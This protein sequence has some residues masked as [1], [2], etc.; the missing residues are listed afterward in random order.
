MS[1]EMERVTVEPVCTLPSGCAASG[2]TNDGHVIAVCTQ[3][4]NRICFSWDGLCGEPFDRLPELRDKSLAIFASDDGNHVAYVGSRGDQVFVGRDGGEDPAFEGFSQS[5]PPVFGGG[6]RHLAY[7]AKPLG[8]EYRLIV[9]GTPVGTAE[10]APIEAAYSL[11]GERLAYVEMRG[12]TRTEVEFRIVLDGQPGEW[13]AGMRNA[14]GAMQFSPDGRRF[15]YYTI[16]GQGHARWFVDGIGQRVINDTRP[17]SLARMRGVGVVDPPLPARFSPDSSRFAYFADVVEKGVAMI[18]DD[19][20]GPLVK[21]V[22]APVFSPDSRHLAYGAQTDVKTVAL[23]LDGVASGEWPATNGGM[24]V[25]SPDGNRLAMT[26]ERE[27]GGLFRKRR[28]FSVAID[29]RRSPEEEAEDSSGTATFSPDGRQIAW[30]LQRNGRA[31]PILDGV[32]QNVPWSVESDVRFDAAGRLVY[33]AQVAGSWT[34]VHGDQPGPLADDMLSLRTL[35]ERFGR[36]PWAHGPS[37]FRISATGQVAWVGVVDG[38]FRP[39]LDDELGP[40][41]DGIL[42][43]QVGHGGDVTWWA[44]RDDVV[45]RVDRATDDVRLSKRV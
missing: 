15:A 28:L 11:D 35:D 44:Q 42:A 16:D 40:A 38:K 23:V 2:V 6:G 1:V 45:Y 20:A 13:F 17:M 14:P 3:P 4:D 29:G 31:A 9:D 19:V 7:G 34:V 12:A 39:V 30:W 37:P 33:G 24:A 10:V 18:E 27:E 21:A 25:F 43:C 36:D 26:L 22:G 5:V 32:I 41:F 8:G